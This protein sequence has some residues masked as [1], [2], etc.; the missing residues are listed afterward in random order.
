MFSALEKTMTSNVS[1]MPKSMFLWGGNPSIYLVNT[2][3]YYFS[4]G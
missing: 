1:S 2:L 4:M 3:I